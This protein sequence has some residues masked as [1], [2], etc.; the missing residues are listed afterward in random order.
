MA[1][2]LPAGKPFFRLNDQ[3]HNDRDDRKKG[4][5]SSSSFFFFFKSND[6]RPFIAGFLSVGSSGGWPGSVGV[7]DDDGWWLG[8][9]VLAKKVGRSNLDI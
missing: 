8:K 5:L 4:L 7:E 1:M 6:Q 9:D 3:T 2:I